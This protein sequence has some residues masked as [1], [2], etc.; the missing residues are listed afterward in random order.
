MNP[1]VSNRNQVDQI[2]SPRDV[3]PKFC[4]R[5]S[6]EGLMWERPWEVAMLPYYLGEQNNL[7]LK[8]LWGKQSA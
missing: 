5:G 6:L 3:R 4:N 2:F 7:H 8:G 1:H